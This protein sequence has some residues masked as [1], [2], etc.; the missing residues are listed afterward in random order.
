MSSSFRVWLFGGILC[1]L[2]VGLSC[3][4]CWSA[5]VL[6]AVTVPFFQETADAQDYYGICKPPVHK[7][8]LLSK[9]QHQGIIRQH[10]AEALDSDTIGFL[11][12]FQYTSNRQHFISPFLDTLHV[13]YLKSPKWRSG[14]N[15]SEFK[16]VKV[17]FIGHFVP[18][19]FFS[20]LDCAQQSD[21]SF[22][23][24]LLFSVHAVNIC[25]I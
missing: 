20:R 17:S 24:T 11:P 3:P 6:P 14:F 4:W 16:S 19:F 21:T 22:F 1:C 25:W 15:I 12:E 9:N 5:R 7:H 2:M 8:A 18:P 23:I 10:Y 13:L